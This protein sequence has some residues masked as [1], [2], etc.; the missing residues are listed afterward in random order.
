MS[1]NGGTD[2]AGGRIKPRE[3]DAVVQGL[4]TGVVPR[5]GLQHVQVGRVG[6]VA[7]LIKDAGRI[8]E[9]GTAFRLVVGEFGSGKT[10]FLNLARSLAMEKR[11]VVASADL[12]PD[13]RLHATGGQARMLYAELMRNLSTR[14][15]PEGG[16]LASVVERFLAEAEKSAVAQSCSIEDAIARRMAPIQDLVSG[17]DFAKVVTHYGRACRE[18]DEAGKTSALRWLRAEYSLKTEAREE[19]G[20][21]SIIDDASVYDYLKVMCCF[22]RLS[23]Y[24]GMVVVLDEMVNL[25]KLVNAQARSANYEQVLRILNDVL[26]GTVEGLGFYL[27]GT[28]EFLLDTRRG[29]FSYPALQ[30]RLAENAFAK[31]GL[32][33]LSG[34][35][36]RL[37]SLKPEDVYV[38]LEKLRNLF[39]AGDRAAYLVPDEALPAFLQHCARKVGDAYFRTP[40]NTIKEFL[41]L[42]AVLEQNPGADWRGLLGRVEI[43][44][45]MA[46]AGGDIEDVPDGVAVHGIA[47]PG[48]RADGLASFKV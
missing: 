30:T 39:A 14:T 36:L 32:V 6:E 34:P 5:L 35:V 20:V 33:D 47:V 24:D 27:G 38:L 45:D 12:A 28:P 4:R 13:R 41:N 40:R 25:F 29:L 31:G 2:T 16:A 15:K 3:R 21:R 22:V 42:L 8:A 11:L 10:F 17:H 46:P 7:Q 26:Q 48:A 9:G 19:L 18:G 1:T 43:A 23:G 37:Q 44:P